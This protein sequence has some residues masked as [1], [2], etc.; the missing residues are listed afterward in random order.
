MSNKQK[1]V[2]INYGNHIG[3]PLRKDESKYIESVRELRNK[4]EL[5]KLV[6]F[7]KSKI[8]TELIK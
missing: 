7:M 3:R 5:K 2:M 8:D 1:G 6:E 4:R